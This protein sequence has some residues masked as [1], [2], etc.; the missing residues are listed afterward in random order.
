M[1][2]LGDSFRESRLEYLENNNRIYY[3][4]QMFFSIF[5]VESILF[6]SNS[7]ASKLNIE[8]KRCDV[9]QSDNDV[10]RNLIIVAY[11]KSIR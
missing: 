2:L 5:S 8:V 11:S 4:D 9:T 7:K 1:Q 6:G 3:S 10:L